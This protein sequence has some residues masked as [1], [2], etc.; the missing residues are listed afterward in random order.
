MTTTTIANTA[1]E[2]LDGLLQGYRAELQRLN[3]TPGTI[4]TYLC[5]IRRL[6]RIM[7]AHGVAVGELTP[8]LAGELV[9]HEPTRVSR[10]PYAVIIAR[11]FAA[12]LVACGLAS[13]PAPPTA[14][15]IAR[16]ELRR[17]YEDF[18]QRQRGLS[19]RTIADCWRFADRFLNFR[20]E[21]ADV[22]LDA[23]TP[24]DVAAYLQRLYSRKTPYRD[25]TP[26]THLRNFFQYLFRR[27]LTPSNLALCVPSV[28]Q[29]PYDARLPRHL[30]PA[31]VEAVLAAV[32]A[33]EPYG[34]RNHAMVL[35]QARIGLRAPEVIAIRLDDIDWRAGALIVRGKGKHHD[36]V[37]IP[38]DVGEALAAYIRHDRA[39]TSRALFVTGRAPH[40]P[41]KD[42]TVLNAILKMAFARTGVTPPC[43]YVGSHVLRHSLAT[44]LVRQGASLAEVGDM[45]R[46]RSRAT[47]MI[48]AK[49]DIDGLRSIA[50]P[51]PVAGGVE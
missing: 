4:H 6:W 10:R 42:G 8:E 38:P 3:Y 1:D 45:L 39:S 33:K 44:N 14:R 47:T 46:H 30:T 40:G 15:E 31:Q 11:R 17:D 34:R 28:A 48:Y 51:W 12:H 19:E 35:L 2:Y 20:F 50:Q 13:P 43:R 25:K 7:E 37:P 23:I 21:E 18:L 36:R 22:S 49:L 24:G 27:G 16:A 29:R 41:F 32:R 26:P 5:T 9:R